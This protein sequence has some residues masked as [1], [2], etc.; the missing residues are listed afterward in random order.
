[1]KKEVFELPAPI[2]GTVWDTD[3]PELPQKVMGYRIGRMMGEDTDDYYEDF[4][5]EVWYI[6]YGC[7]GIEAS[8]PVSEI[9]VSIFLTRDEM[10]AA[11]EN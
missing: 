8:V 2:G 7:C 6:Q 5:P 11:V 9:G 10:M 4:D 1:M 3:Y